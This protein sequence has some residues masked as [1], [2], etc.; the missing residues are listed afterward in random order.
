M[1]NESVLPRSLLQTRTCRSTCVMYKI[2]VVV[3]KRTMVYIVVNIVGSNLCQATVFGTHAPKRVLHT[4][5]ALHV[6]LSR[7]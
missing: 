1:D 5:Q 6:S 4:T 7:S 2:K 3:F